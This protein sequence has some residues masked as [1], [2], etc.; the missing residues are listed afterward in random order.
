MTAPSSLHE[1]NGLAPTGA[2]SDSSSLSPSSAPISLIDAHHHLW[3]LDTHHYP[4]LQDAI[5]P[6]FFLGDYSALR[7]TNYLPPDYLADS[8]AVRLLAT[9]HCEAEHDRADQV[10]ETRWITEQSDRYGFPNAIVAH[11]WF[12]HDTCEDILKRHCAYPLVRGIRS[13]PVTAPT[14]QQ[15]A[16]VRGK[17][18]SMQDPNWIRGFSLL[19]KH[20]LS[21]DLRVPYWHLD[22]AAVIARA[23]P[24]VRIVLNHTGF[25][26]DRSPAGLAAWREA[27]HTIAACPNVWVKIS[28]LGLKDAPWNAVDNRVVVR[29]TLA[30][31]GIERCMF[32][33]NFPVAKIRIGYTDLVTAIDGMLDGYTDTEKEGFFWRNAHAFYRIAL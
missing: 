10:E 16:E 26:W 20:D 12:H 28:E 23:F 5:D 9:V 25:P 21:W 33:S 19:E 4:W 3:N 8:A 22:E 18:G 2:G 31:F 11:V 15:K 6:H 24:G 32:A 1:R 14:P 7:S 30:I 13:K 17:P 27:M 29:D